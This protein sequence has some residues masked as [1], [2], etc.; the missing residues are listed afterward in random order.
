MHLSTSLL[1]VLP[2]QP[3]NLIWLLKDPQQSDPHTKP[4]LPLAHSLLRGLTQ[5]V[6]LSVHLSSDNTEVQTQP[7]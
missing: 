5:A 4:H 1:K 2:K 7:S 3:M 6:C